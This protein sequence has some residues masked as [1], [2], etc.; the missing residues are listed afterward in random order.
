M[1]IDDRRIQPG[2]SIDAKIQ[3][4]LAFRRLVPT[5]RAPR[6][7]ALELTGFDQSTGTHYRKD[8]Q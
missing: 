7:L 1:Y 2:A 4:R 3:M 8:A 5:W 6:G